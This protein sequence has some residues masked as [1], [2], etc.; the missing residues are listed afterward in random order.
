MNFYKRSDVIGFLKAASY[1]ECVVLPRDWENLPIK[2]LQNYCVQAV[3]T[4]KNRMQRGHVFNT[5]KRLQQ[6]A[7]RNRGK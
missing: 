4:A 1:D 3:N 5:E 2:I 6:V 7:E